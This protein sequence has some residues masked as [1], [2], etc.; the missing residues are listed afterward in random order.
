MTIDFII[1]KLGDNVAQ[2]TLVNWLVDDG[3]VVANGDDLL[4]LET[5]KATMSLPAPAAGV[6]KI[7]PFKA[8]DI[9]K[10]AQVVGTITPANG[11]NAARR[12]RPFPPPRQPNRPRNRKPPPPKPLPWP[13]KWPMI[14][15]S[16]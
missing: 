1:P 11:E 2:A 16:I 14:W 8:G 5:D 15:A 13:K 10:V 12:P 9:V 3:A 7:G 4:E 6:L